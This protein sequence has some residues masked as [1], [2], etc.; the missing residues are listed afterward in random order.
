MSGEALE[1][2]LNLRIVVKSE[3]DLDKLASKIQRDICQDSIEFITITAFK[4]AIAK[5][6]TRKNYGIE[7]LKKPVCID[8]E[9]AVKNCG[10]TRI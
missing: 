4:D 6:A 2:A 7:S 8:C 1:V 3:P 9:K 5:I 10:L